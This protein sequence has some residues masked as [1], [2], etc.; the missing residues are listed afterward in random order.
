MRFQHHML[1]GTEKLTGLQ[2]F[3]GVSAHCCVIAEV[4]TNEVLK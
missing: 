3:V 4:D 1:R 2:G